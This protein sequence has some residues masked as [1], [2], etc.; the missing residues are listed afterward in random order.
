MARKNF[1]LSFI[2]LIGF[3]LSASIYPEVLEIDRFSHNTSVGYEDISERKE[4]VS[5]DAKLVDN[6]IS[7]LSSGKI[8]LKLEN[9]LNKTMVVH[10]GPAPPFSVIY[11]QGRK[12]EKFLLWSPSY[13]ES[14]DIETDG[15]F[16]HNFVQKITIIAPKET[17]TQEY[18]I[19]KSRFHPGKYRFKQKLKHSHLD[20]NQTLAPETY[21]DLSFK[22]I[23][24]NASFKIS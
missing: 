15:K 5:I 8:R 10:S 7:L 16:R 12:N 4:P 17:L 6:R 11:A 13:K 2:F 23:Q 21:T 19:E 24:I 18:R 1:L 20:K 3:L 22:T 9:K 14:E